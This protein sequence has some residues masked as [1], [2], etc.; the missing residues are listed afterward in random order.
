MREER[1]SPGNVDHKTA[2]AAFLFALRF[3]WQRIHRGDGSE[4]DADINLA[5]PPA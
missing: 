4:M 5:N 3:W 1:V 2:I